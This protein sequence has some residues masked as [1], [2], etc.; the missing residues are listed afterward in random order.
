M[1]S[2]TNCPAQRLTFKSKKKPNEELSIAAQ[3]SII[4]YDDSVLYDKYINPAIGTG[5]KIINYRTPWSGI[6]P[7]HMDGAVP[8]HVARN[9]ILDIISDCIVVGHNIGSD[10]HS[11][12]IHNFPTSQIRDTSFNHN[13]KK[14][15][16]LPSNNQPGALKKMA[17]ALLGRRI[18]M[19]SRV[20]HCSVEDATATMDLYRLEELEWEHGQD[21]LK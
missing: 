1:G 3:C 8:F 20:G 14:R 18:Q 13:L 16:G 15:A 11:L 12:E 5:Y 21:Q 19:R 4:G 17:L 6:A 10:F 7:R 9:E 2:P